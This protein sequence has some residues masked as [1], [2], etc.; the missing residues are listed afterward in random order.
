MN[1]IDE[2]T[3]SFYRQFY[4][5][6]GQLIQTINN[7][8]KHTIETIESIRIQP[9]DYT[10]GDGLELSESQAEAINEALSIIKDIIGDSK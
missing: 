3:Y 5:Q 4:L 9:R 6:Y 2:Q 10:K 1:S 8:P 7:L